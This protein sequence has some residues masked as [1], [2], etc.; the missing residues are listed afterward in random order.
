MKG[1]L[2]YINVLSKMKI[3]PLKGASVRTGTLGIVGS[4]SMAAA[5]QAALDLIY[6]LTPAQYDAYPKTSRSNAAFCSSST[7]KSSASKDV[8]TPESICKEIMDRRQF[9]A[10][11]TAA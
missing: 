3:T 1:K 5:D 10:A 9:L 6:G 4:L 7:L 8:A 11:A 2:L